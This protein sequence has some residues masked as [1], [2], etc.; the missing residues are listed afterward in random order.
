[1]D[2]LLGQDPRSTTFELLRPLAAA[3]TAV[4]FATWN[5]EYRR[6]GSPGG[7]W[8]ATFLDVGAATDYLRELQSSYPLDPARVMVAGHSAGGQ[9]AL[10]IAARS[11]LPESS[12]LFRKTPLPLKAA[13][14]ID[15]PPDLA[16]AQPEERTFCPVPGIS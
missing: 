16:S 6:A 11:K 1:V 12:R 3:L 7:G 10:W 4:G 9:F 15:G 14:D 2:R 8:P 5:I 13:V